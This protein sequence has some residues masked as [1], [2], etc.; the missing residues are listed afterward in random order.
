[1]GSSVVFEFELGEL[2][3]RTDGPKPI[4]PTRIHSS[5]NHYLLLLHFQTPLLLPY[6]HGPN[7]ADRPKVD[8]RKGKPSPALSSAHP[9]EHELTTTSSLFLIFCRLPESSLPPRLPESRPPPPEESRSLTDTDPELS[10]SVR[11]GDTRRSA[12]SPPPSCLLPLLT[13]TPPSC[14]SPVD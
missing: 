4:A 14:L 1:M 13:L 8:R 9:I 11:S 10:L 2:G 5:S 12:H 6:H 7:Q 3:G